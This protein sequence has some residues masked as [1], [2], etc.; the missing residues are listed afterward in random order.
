MRERLLVVVI[1]AG[2]LLGLPA[3]LF[4]QDMTATIPP[5]VTIHVVQRGETLFKIATSYNLSVDE[6]ARL[7]NISDP[8][9]IYV[10][11]RLLVP[12]PGTTPVPTQ[13][14]MHV[15]QPGESLE[16]IA[17][18]YDITVDDLRTRNSLTD[19]SSFYVGRLLDVSSSAA[20]PAPTDTPSAPSAPDS[21]I[22]HTVLRGET[23]FK[24]ATQYGG[25]GNDIVQ[26]NH[27][28]DPQLIFAGQQL[29][30]PAY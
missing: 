20:T 24:I 2:M 21:V 22:M 17:G 7:N 23:M 8:S 30:I 10:G 11:Q 6:L 1:V 14:V 9:V 18:L 29:I 5:G 3:A 12:A 28:T 15:V 13:S 4:A 27:L 16:S 26:A 25:S 19:G